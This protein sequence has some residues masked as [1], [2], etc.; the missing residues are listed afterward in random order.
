MGVRDYFC[1]KYFF[2]F[3]FLG[4]TIIAN[5]YTIGKFNSEH[6]MQMS[7]F[8]PGLLNGQVCSETGAFALDCFITLHRIGNVVCASRGDQ[9]CLA[10]VEGML[11][12]KM[13]LLFSNVDYLFHEIC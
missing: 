7:Q 4:L 12:H 10:A 3:F 11:P 9:T 2:L 5:L 13:P 1:P 8:S 6:E